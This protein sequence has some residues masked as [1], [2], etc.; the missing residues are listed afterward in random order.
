MEGEVGSSA[1]LARNFRSVIS[2]EQIFRRQ[3][4]FS[5]QHFNDRI[6]GPKI[7]R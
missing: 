4:F 7:R 1:H 5:N 2:T 3:I 6:F